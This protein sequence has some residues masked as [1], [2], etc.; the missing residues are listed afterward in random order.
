LTS[1]ETYGIV[2]FNKTFEETV[3]AEITAIN[4]L[5]ESSGG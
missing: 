3:E 2:I 4:A 1:E 5:T